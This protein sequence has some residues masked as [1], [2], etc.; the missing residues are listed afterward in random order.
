M[1]IPVITEVTVIVTKGLKRNLEAMPGKHSIESLHK[2]GVVG[3][4][5][6]NTESAVV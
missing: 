4:L 3:T 1:I 6:A 2:T 5:T